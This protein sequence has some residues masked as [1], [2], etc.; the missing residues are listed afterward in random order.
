MNMLDFAFRR[1]PT[2]IMNRAIPASPAINPTC[3]KLEE[4][5]HGLLPG[6]VPNWNSYPPFGFV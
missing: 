3:G 5:V 4:I 6:Y 1:G 2:P